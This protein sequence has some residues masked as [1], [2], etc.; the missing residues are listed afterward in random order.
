MITRLTGWLDDITG[1]VTMYR[2]VTIALTALVLEALLVSLLGQLP[3]QDALSILT[4]TVVAVGISY[5]SGRLFALIFRVKPHGESALITGLILALLFQPTFTLPGLT[6]VAVAAVLAN[7]SKYILAI[8]RRHIFNPAAAGALLAG[9]VVPSAFSSNAIAGWW[10]ASPWLLPVTIVAAFV[11]LYRTRHLTLGLVFI[12]IAAAAIVVPQVVQGQ[13][14][15]T[16]LGGAFGSFPIVFFAGVMLSEPLTLPPRRRQQ[17][18]EAAV[19]A[20]LFAF[21]YLFS[22]PLGIGAFYGGYPLALLIGNLLAFLV[23]QRRA[24]RLEFIGREPLSPTAWELSFKPARPIRFTAGQFIELTLPH[25]GADVRGLRR[26]FSIASAP[27]GDVITVGIRIAE[28]SSTFKSTLLALQPGEIVAATAVGGDFVLPKDAAKPVLLVAGGIG[29]TPYMSHLAEL[30]ATGDKRD[31]VLVYSSSYVDDLAYAERLNNADH[32]V[33]LVA[34]TAP[35]VLPEHWTYLGAGPLTAEL[36]TSAV[37]DA[38]SRAAYV[39]G[40]PTL[41]RTLRPALRRAGV[42]SVKTDYFS[43]Y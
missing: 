36:L 21:P 13:P 28:R 35:S 12:V 14:L 24:I 41:V 38:R 4:S 29:I 31:V 34:P 2:L 16:A 11:I 15:G 22:I 23:G 1:R 37:P 10:I 5:L 26:T 27:S 8:R 3:G 40:A 30:E 20:V 9:V 7:A 17:I 25:R 32:R 42:R 19:V 39:S 43:G 6:T 18:A 33:F